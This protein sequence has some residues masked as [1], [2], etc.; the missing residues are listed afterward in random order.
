MHCLCCLS[1]LSLDLG[2]CHGFLLSLLPCVGLPSGLLRHGGLLLRSGG[3]L[4]RRG[5][6]LLRSGGLLLQ[7]GGP[8]LRRGGLLLYRGERL[9]RPGGL[10]SHL[11]HPGGLLLRLLRPGVLLLCLLRPEG[12]R[13]I[14]SALVGSCY[15]CSAMVGLCSVGPVLAS[16]STLA[17][18]S[19]RFCLGPRPLHFHVDLTLRALG[20]LH[21]T[22]CCTSPKTTFPLIH[23][24]DDTQLITLIT[25]LITQSHTLYKSWTTSLWSPS[26]V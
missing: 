13:P 9:L 11:L 26:I 18:Y 12:S 23:C 16:G 14:R 20:L 2:L 15:V 25:Q 22:N 5:G 8:L 24:T 4:L 6:L 21:Y 19:A 7:S 1:L 3:L 17:S 10:T